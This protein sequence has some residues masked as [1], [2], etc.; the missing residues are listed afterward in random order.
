MTT[1]ASRGLVV[2]LAAAVACSFAL[3][4]AAPVAAGGGLVGDGPPLASGLDGTV[5]ETVAGAGDVVGID[6]RNA[7]IDGW[8]NGTA[9][10]G[11]T[12]G[13]ELRNETG[14][15]TAT[16][17][18][19]STPTSASGAAADWT[20]DADVL[21]VGGTVET[22]GDG[23][24]NAVNETAD[25][26]TDTVDGTL[27]A[28]S[29]T[30]VG[31]VNGTG[32]AVAGTVNA[33]GEAVTGIVNGT[34]ETV[35][36]TVTGT[37]TAATETV[38]GTGETVEGTTDAT[39]GGAENV[40]G[41]VTGAAGDVTA[42]TTDETTGAVTDATGTVSATTGA[43][44]NLTA[45]DT[46][47]TLTEVV[48][49]GTGGL[50]R[51]TTDAV[52]GTITG[53][54]E[55][56]GTLLEHVVA[57][58]DGGEGNAGTAEAHGWPTAGS[59]SAGGTAEGAWS[60]GGPTAEQVDPGDRGTAADGTET[61]ETGGGE[62]A[63]GGGL[64]SGWPQDPGAGGAAVGAMLVVGSIVA[65]RSGMAVSNAG[66]GATGLLQ[67]LFA[68]LRGLFLRVAVLAGYSRYDFEDPLENENR[69]AILEAVESSPGINL[70]SIMAATGLAEGTVRYHL[71]V[72]EHED[73]L[74][75]AKVRGRR[76]YVPRTDADIELVAAFEEEA[77]RDVLET[78]FEHEPATGTTL[79]ESLGRDPSTVSHHLSRLADA[80]LVDREQDGPA[81][82][83]SLA[84]AVRRAFSD[85]EV[86][87]SVQGHAGADD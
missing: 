85:V 60:G 4:A 14:D 2:A 12:N 62:A 36:E 40:T 44:G 10:N 64:P 32:E 70:T 50:V 63:G 47:A 24:A 67:G 57:A 29:E 34:G 49:V 83:N 75:G 15:G 65:T 81:L 76:R 18:G 13:T 74:E 56:A 82:R 20:N 26:T 8:T 84:P 37:G 27:N 69:A 45:A 87:A 53:S 68:A 3:G 5:G 35:D 6:G 19:T 51:W 42:G 16:P 46:D 43:I 30:V 31:T 41:D 38:N 22:V 66:A 80:G 7:S 33:T 73:L 23:T 71:R 39:V 17:D 58:T 72:L 86:T 79:A 78:L 21:D 52:T 48:V 11:T 9:A 77:T 55:G 54:V 28:T 61:N 25:G 1:R 59:G